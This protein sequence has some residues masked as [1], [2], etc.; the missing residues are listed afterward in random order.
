MSTVVDPATGQREFELVTYLITVLAPTST[1]DEQGQ[2][3]ADAITEFIDTT[4]LPGGAIENGIH[5]I[6]AAQGRTVRVTGD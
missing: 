2:R 6:A 4:V 5:L 3:L 1:T